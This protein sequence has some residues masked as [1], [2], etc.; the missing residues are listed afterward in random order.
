[1]GKKERR[2]AFVDRL[3]RRY[4]DDYITECLDNAFSGQSNHGDDLTRRYPD[5]HDGMVSERNEN[6]L[7]ESNHIEV[8]PH[9]EH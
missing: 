1:M 7:R 4:G 9:D 2:N 6:S 5:D 3:T 8:N